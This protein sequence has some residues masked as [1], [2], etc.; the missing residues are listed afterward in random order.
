LRC[1]ACGNRETRVVDS[2]ELDEAATIRRRR[3]CST[4]GSRFTTYERVESPRLAVL[5]RDGSRQEFDRG[6]LLSGLQKSLAGRPVAQGAAQAAAEQI[7]TQLRATGTS[8]VES[9]RIGELV[10]DQLD[11]LDRLA[12]LRFATHFR[13]ELTEAELSE[14]ARARRSQQ[15]GAA[16]SDAEP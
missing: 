8:E 4:C 16:R 10:L 11:R 3:E 12:Y 15:E 2:R 13:D 1:P 5:K 14:L 7:E 6:R 9:T